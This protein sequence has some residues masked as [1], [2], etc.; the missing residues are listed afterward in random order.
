M[1][2][3]GPFAVPTFEALLDSDHEVPL[4]VTRP[5]PPRG[6]RRP[7]PNPMRD[8]A[9]ARGV[10]VVAPDSVNAEETQAELRAL[11]PD[12]LVVC[13]YG[14]IL[15]AKT[16][17]AA[18]L[19]GVNLHA[20]LLPEYRGAAPINWALWD[21][22]EETGVT[23]IHMTPKLDGGPN[24]VQVKTAIE[25]HENAGQLEQR[26]SQMGVAPVMRAIEML[27]QWDRQ[28]PIGEKQDPQKATKA[29]RLHKSQG[30]VDWTQPAPKIVCQ[31]RAL[32]PWP[33]VYMLWKK[34]GS[35]EMR[36]IL[37]RVE[38]ATDVSVPAEAIPGE[39]VRV[40]KSELIVAA[41]EGAVS[42]VRVQPAGKRVMEVAEFLRGHALR[43]GQRLCVE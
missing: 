14:Q 21:G 7:P 27:G 25:P 38:V 10:A 22:R 19:G 32:Q 31:V 40:G 18:P 4:L 9:E 37:D 3:T 29:P 16:L 41:G 11:Q 42:L 34:E 43:V 35:Q 30:L 28:S 36:M 8:A 6:R 2:G 17:E 33:G 15:S 5:T 12:L 24:L 20:S 1:M 23:V 26:L 13:D 39:I